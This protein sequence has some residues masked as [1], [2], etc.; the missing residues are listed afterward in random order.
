[1]IRQKIP[2]TRAPGRP[3]GKSPAATFEKVLRAFDTGGLSFSEVR[4][5]LKQQ[6][7]EG[8]SPEDLL[9][10]MR[11][12]ELI[13]PLPE[14]AHQEILAILQAHRQGG[15]ATDGADGGAA[16]DD[17]AAQAASDQ[18]SAADPDFDERTMSRLL[19]TLKSEWAP[20]PA[21][22]AELTAELKTMR[23]ALDKRDE[24]LE[25]LRNDHA[26][27]MGLLE[28]RAR[29]AAQ[30][31]GDLREHT[32]AL[33]G[34][35]DALQAQQNMNRELSEALADKAAA[36]EAA[37][38][39]GV[40]A[41][42]RGEEALR[43]AER[44]QAE[45]TALHDTVAASD[46]ALEE[47]RRALEER[48]S[49]LQQARRSLDER[50]SALEK[51]RYSLSEHTAALDQARQLLSDRD[52]R[53]ESLQQNA[54]LQHTIV[55]APPMESGA[56]S[57]EQLQAELKAARERS[58]ALEADLVAAH[59]A[60]GAEQN[61]SRRFDSVFAEHKALLTERS[62]LLAEQ[63]ALA[64]ERNALLNEKNAREGERHALHGQ[65]SSLQRSL[66]E[67]TAELAA[68]KQEHAKVLPTF[69]SRIRVLETELKESRQRIDSMGAAL[70]ASRA[71]AAANASRAPDP[72]RSAA[73]QA[74][75]AVEVAEFTP[76]PGVK[77][78]AD[79]NEFA[80]SPP[81]NWLRNRLVRVT[82]LCL[83]VVAAVVGIRSFSNHP[84]AAK[85]PEVA[86]ASLS[87]PGSVIRDCEACPALTVLPAGRFKQGSSDPNS[88]AFVKPM[89]WV[90]IEHP[91]AMTTSD[92][93]VAEFRAFATATG[94]SMQGCDVYDG[95]WKHQQA[96]S[97]QSPGFDQTAAHPVTCASWEDAKAYAQWLS[98]QTGH[99]Y[100]LP[101]ASEWEY[102]ARAGGDAA[103]P[104]SGNGSDACQNANVADASAAHRFPG[105]VAFACNDGYVYTS[106]VGSFKASRFGLSDMLGNVFQWTEDCW[107]PNY[108]RA[109]IDGSARTDGNCAE[110]ELRGGSWFTFPEYVR[111]DYRN[112]F[113]A[114]YRASSIGVRLVRDVT[115]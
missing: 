64:T 17:Q 115:P 57:Y 34:A 52:T 49:A 90:T 4:L 13:E 7:T 78:N 63:E 23:I 105:W 114:D 83:L 12:R 10:V 47:A 97:W 41:V 81:I 24:E 1:L 68:Q 16:S 85:V 5:T 56:Q 74:K 61:K 11:Q 88:S 76:S 28:A 3:N 30:L 84:S 102:A 71:S 54:E 37:K 21:G 44:Y 50:D 113:A 82:A 75:P 101:S 87:V 48:D 40:E 65:L 19:Q 36:D 58:A 100:R 109:P 6:L 55:M 95:Q 14:Y 53:I 22:A 89:H 32:A 35:Q 51:A 106:P 104:W 77:R 91:I 60:L 46:A 69:T 29:S 67:R 42:A 70:N 27:V 39:R 92:V 112:H 86:P 38:V 66:D 93:T 8:A 2:P 72:Q 20:E 80:L 73:A 45:L 103:Q 15:A 79:I 9:K 43:S 62:A 31:E 99:H 59:T 107:N 96:G 26:R 111:A 98:A 94:R 110:H 18:E 108:S 33:R 25:A